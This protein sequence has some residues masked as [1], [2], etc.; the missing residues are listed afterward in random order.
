MA[1]KSSRKALWK[2][3]TF[4]T[5]FFVLSLLA[6]LFMGA[7][8]WAMA[9][10]RTMQRMVLALQER[11]DKQDAHVRSLQRM[12]EIDALVLVEGRYDDALKAYAELRR[13]GDMPIADAVDKR[14]TALN[15]L[16]S[17][18]SSDEHSTDPKDML[19][20]QY[21][22]T[23]SDLE[24]RTEAVQRSMGQLS[25]SLQ[26]RL[27]DII[28]ELK[29]KEKELGRK[30]QVQVLSFSSS[31]GQKIHYLGEVKDGKAHGGGVGIWTTGSVYRG[32]W[33]N[34][35]RHGEGTFEWA[36]GERYE[37]IYVDGIREGFGKYYWPNGDRYEGQWKGDRRNGEGTLFDM[38]SN[39]RFRGEWKDDKPQ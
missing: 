23:I 18:R 8:V 5:Y 31:K 32:Q 19:L 14:V 37:G 25:D 17:E 20:S 12:A 6:L 2:N 15:E 38:D 35:L 22:Q 26:T 3:K 39:V 16:L 33:R 4:L 11:T 10:N 13:S 21:R 9:Q 27:E 29:R 30:E 7:T 1:D 36:D 28:T 34:N 24:I